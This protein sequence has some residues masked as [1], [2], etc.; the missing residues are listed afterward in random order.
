MSTKPTIHQA[1]L[2]E[3]SIRLSDQK[4]SGLSVADWCERNSFS[5]Y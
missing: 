1:R 5:V 3:W 4:A 2:N